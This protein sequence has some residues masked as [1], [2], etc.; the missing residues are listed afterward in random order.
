MKHLESAYIGQNEW[1]KYVLLLLIAFVGGQFIGAIPLAIVLGVAGANGNVSPE[2]IATMNF[3]AMGINS[4]LGLALVIL[5]FIV[6]LILFMVL[7]KAFHQR[8]VSTVINGTYNIR[9]RR[10]IIGAAVWGVIIAFAL[11]V[12]YYLNI[13]NYEVRLNWRAL[14]PLAIVAVVLIPFQA[15]CEEILFRGYLAQGIG[16][17]TKSRLLVL[18]IPSLLFA[19][20]H[21]TN[22]EVDKFGFWAV[23]PQYFTM[24]LVYALISVLDDGIELAMGAH[25]VNNVFLSI[26]LTADGMVFQTDALLKVHEVDPLKDLGS[27]LIGCAVFCAALAFKYRWKI[28]TLFSRIQPPVAEQ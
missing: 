20:M 18:L 11:V 16:R 22:P 21:G 2:A 8:S 9:W 25:A 6:V 7:Y 4:T 23:M 17:L 24:G 27:L 1:W 10:V 5:P 3:N 15:F 19:L 28:H 26:F 14:I 13:D 12:D